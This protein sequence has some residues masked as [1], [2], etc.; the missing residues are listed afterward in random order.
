MTDMPRLKAAERVLVRMSVLSADSAAR[1]RSDRDDPVGYLR[2][3]IADPL[4]REAIAVSSPSLT[5]T[6]DAL[7]AGRPVDPKKLRR[8]VVS[9]SRYVLRM[10]TRATP[11][12]V[13]AGVSEAHFDQAAK[14]E[15][16]D[17]HRKSARPDVGWLHALVRDWERRPEVVR[18]LRV[19]RN[20]LCFIR[21]DRLVLPHLPVGDDGPALEVS[22]RRTPV[23]EAVI[24]RA[25]RPV[26]FTELTE[27]LRAAFPQ[28]SPEAVERVLLQLIERYLLLT[29]L[30]PPDDADP[31]RHVLDR[32]P[33][34]ERAG[35]EEAAAALDAYAATPMA[36][37]LTAWNDVLRTTRRLGDKQH[38][39]H[40]DVGLDAEVTLPWAVAEE[41]ESVAAVL[42]RVTPPDRAAPHMRAYY[43]DFVDRYG[44]GRLVPV[45]ELL[46]SEKGLGTPAGYRTSTRNVSRPEPN[47]YRERVFGELAQRALL[48]GVHEVE[49]DAAMIER[50]SGADDGRVPPTL[51]I[52]AHVLAES[53]TAL[54]DGD[55]R[56]ALATMPLS[57]RAGALSGRF[58][59]LLDG[60][61]DQ[62][63]RILNDDRTVRPQLTFQA[64]WT[65][66]SNVARVPLLTDHSLPVGTFA[67]PGDPSVID[68]D[69]LVVGAAGGRLFVHSLTRD[70]EIAPTTVHML[71]V[72]RVGPEVARFLYDITDARARACNA[73]TWG[74]LDAML[75]FLPRVRHGRTILASATWRPAV[76]LVDAGLTESEWSRRLDAWRERWRVPSEVFMTNGDNRIGLDL[77]APLH[78]RILRHELSRRPSTLLVESPGGEGFGTGWSNGRANEI[79][80]TLS[81]G[82]PEP[83]LRT[84]A[85]V[86]DR[87]SAH[88]PGG[89]WLF[90]K[91]YASAD[92]HTDLIS[93]RL[94]TLRASLPP[95]VDRWFFIR[96]FDPEPHLRLRFHGSP[97]RLNAEVLPLVHDWAA[98]LCRT[99]LARTLVLDTYEPEVER[100][101]GPEALE[102]AERVFQADSEAV[103]EQLRLRLPMRPELL[104]AANYVDLVRAF[105]DPN[106]RDWFLHA[107]PKGEHHSAFQAIR[108]TAVEVIDGRDLDSRLTEVWGRRR[109]AVA[110]Y[111][112]LIRSLNHR[113]PLH[114]L[115]HMH[116]NRLIGAAPDAEGASYAIARGALQALRD[117]D[118]HAK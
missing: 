79:V 40:V 35:L 83:A 65:R 91:L 71:V 29:E 55:F 2:S 94:P 53:V 75:P 62:T 25:R 85:A 42:T 74:E 103:I 59:Y 117:R 28:G 96:Y 21:G 101:G 17:D 93:Q 49:L 104:A 107:Y 9:V 82:S 68:L 57:R 26:P 44:T 41:L 109:T 76:G 78:R 50:L 106:W 1:T 6:L 31:V 14:V 63:A 111:G 20:N 22:V 90:A 13:M 37:G 108:R 3:L 100:Y 43:D 60:L 69:D 23:V 5:H 24:E 48:D 33:P 72:S 114:A 102:A 110:A 8:A 47:R 38:A 115:L 61:R 116:H 84:S 70:T 105:G 16:G 11:F 32:L 99:G 67:D 92:R 51:E 36:E 39:P 98:E 19:V 118:R 54:E 27:H 66:V 89:E 77:D 87:P 46:D 81:T 86:R 95:S 15:F 7:E 113:T 58:V 10:A 80:V 73:W 56:L 112:R 4:V 45:K 97:D 30:I 12:G 34:G 88:R 52:G 18:R 64:N